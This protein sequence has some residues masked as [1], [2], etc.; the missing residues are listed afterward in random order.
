VYLLALHPENARLN[1]TSPFGC[2]TDRTSLRKWTLLSSR[3]A[4]RELLRLLAL[5]CCGHPFLPYLPY[6]RAALFRDRSLPLCLRFTLAC[7]APRDVDPGAP[8][9]AAAALEIT[10]DGRATCTAD[11][12]GA[13]LDPLAVP[14]FKPSYGT[15]NS[16]FFCLAYGPHLRSHAGTDDFQFNDPCFRVTR[17][18]SLFDESARLTDPV[19]FL[20]RLHYRAIRCSRVP[21]R[22]TLQRLCTLARDHLG[23]ES[24][25]W[26][27][28]DRGFSEAW[29]QLKPSQQRVMLPV[30]DAVR[31]V[32]DANPHRLAPLD[33]PGVI[34]MDRPDRWCP[35][36]TFA[37][38]IA[39][40][41]RLLPRMQFVVTLGEEARR[42]VPA[43]VRAHHL[44]LPAATTAPPK[45]RPGRLEPGTVLLIDVDSR[46]PNVA[47]MKLSRH[48]RECGRAVKLL[49]KEAFLPGADAVYTSSVFST[50]ASAARVDR[51]RRYYGDAMQV[52]G[53]GVD[54]KRRLP[55]EIEA[56]PADFDLYPELEGRAIGFLT[57]GCSSRCSFC[58]VP[59][60]EGPVRRVSDLDPL[61]AG[62]KKLILLDDNILAH[63]DAGALLE[64]MAGR[65]VKVNFT[66]TLDLRFLSRELAAI[67]KRVHCSNTRFTR[68]NYHFSLNNSRELD[69]VRAAYGMLGLGR[70]DHAEFVCMYGFATTLREDV[71]RFRFLR[72]LPGA[73]VF[74][75]EYQPILGGPAPRPIELFDDDANK[76]IDELV[77]IIF[78]QNMKSMERYYRWLSRR[79]AQRF[80]AL[81]PT[82]VDTIF[83]YNRRDQRGRYVAS[84][85]G[86]RPDRS[87]DAEADDDGA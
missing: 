65:E 40:T 53:S 15:G 61:L 49:R 84:L 24:E 3:P 10:P 12:R 7:H 73:Y 6:D 20:T 48:C 39:F 71:E 45:Q 27:D 47:L 75:Q 11:A 78:P 70:S 66:Q 8:A 32:L 1:R 63:P 38:W 43:S 28:R 80:G 14:G 83:R 29:R 58:V 41:D 26:L 13:S 36:G 25:S 18:A 9:V 68:P 55:P 46:L 86:T 87:I 52:G 19:Q 16:R 54:L 77:T 31:H 69:R 17:A 35:Q 44:P 74:V 34:L 51:L 2:D 22:D 57:R 33:E 42:K 59:Q 76:L 81:H 85:A 82:L 50:P 60:K 4:D 23:I 21:A 62:R 67:L 72:S 56:L 79:Y 30:L 64:E 37:A 5:A